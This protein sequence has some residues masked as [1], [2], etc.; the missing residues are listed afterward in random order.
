MA[1]ARVLR[2]FALDRIAVGFNPTISG[3]EAA[4]FARFAEEHGFDSFWVHENPFIKDAISLLS[5]AILATEKIKIGAGCV[6]VVTRHPLLTVSTFVSLDETSG[7]RVQMGVGLGGFPWLP[8]IG[9]KVF[10]VQETRPLKRIREFLTITDKLL[11]GESISLDGEFYKVA[12]IKLESKPA[13]RPPVYLAAFG[14]RLLK[15]ASRFVDGV[16]ISPALMTPEITSQKVH[17]VRGGEDA[18]N[19]VDIASYILTTVSNDIAKARQAMKSYYFLLYQVA[20]VIRPEIFAPYG[21]KPRDLEPIKE[22][23][24]RRDIA[25]AAK[26]LP[27]EVIDALTLT[28]NPDHCVERLKDYRK[29]GVDLPIIMPIGDTKAAIEAFATS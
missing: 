15:M 14:E 26:A 5:N 27:D 29:A 11:D 7:R 25:A 6:S 17:F 21:L 2:D 13:H 1:C 20:E 18:G 3:R 28:G 9:V 12:D 24:R 19:R 4:D 22:A 16:I 23:W 10:P 8:K